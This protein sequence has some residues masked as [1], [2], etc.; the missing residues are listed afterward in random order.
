[1]KKTALLLFSTIIFGGINAQSNDSTHVKLN[2]LMQS[3]RNLQKDLNE[4]K[5]NL[6]QCHEV[7]R[8][9][10]LITAIGIGITGIGAYYN[11]E[12]PIYSG[13]ALILIGT[14]TMI[15]SHTYIRKAG[16]GIGADGIT[17]KYSF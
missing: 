2:Y 4:V 7:Y 6:K 3:N 5:L 12:G 15:Y 9:G 11:A 1:M 8:A 17:I 10:V 13:G 16:V 14:G